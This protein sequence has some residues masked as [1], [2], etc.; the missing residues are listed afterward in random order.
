MRISY[1]FKAIGLLYSS[2]VP[3]T[4]EL[5]LCGLAHLQWTL[6]LALPVARTPAGRSLVQLPLLVQSRN[7]E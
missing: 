5:S 7:R 6:R 3:C 2:Y 1:F 4:S